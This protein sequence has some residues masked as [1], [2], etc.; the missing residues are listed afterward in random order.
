M[1][2]QLT[3]ADCPSYCSTV[4]P[5]FEI[6]GIADVIVY[7]NLVIFKNELW[8]LSLN[9]YIFPICSSSSQTEIQC[10]FNS[11]FQTWVW[12]MWVTLLQRFPNSVLRPACPA[13]FPA[14]PGLFIA[15]YLDHVCSVSQKMEDTPDPAV[16]RAGK[17]G[18]LVGEGAWGL[19][20]ETTALMDNPT[21]H[22]TMTLLQIICIFH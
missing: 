9:L 1:H 5:A 15:D 13:C 16:S 12:A 18:K 4:A 14:I 21:F 2:W 19:N 22:Q 6:Y 7:E 10:I 11:H 8:C 20:L 17:A 3:F